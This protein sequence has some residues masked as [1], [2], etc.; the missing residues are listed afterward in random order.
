MRDGSGGRKKGRVVLE[1]G[2]DE[3][4]GASLQKVSK[5]SRWKKAWMPVRL[6]CVSFRQELRSSWIP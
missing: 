5:S 2:S 1:G 4:A 6:R 3:P